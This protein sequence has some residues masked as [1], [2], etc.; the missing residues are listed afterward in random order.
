MVEAITKGF[1]RKV[2]KEFRP[3]FI[4][5]ILFASNLYTKNRI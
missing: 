1:D 5:T 3:S 4:E 2:K